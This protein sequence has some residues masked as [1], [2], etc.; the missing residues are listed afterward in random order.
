[1]NRQR[2]QFTSDFHPE[3]SGLDG[4]FSFQRSAA[5]QRGDKVRIG[6]QAVTATTSGA[7][8]TLFTVDTDSQ[9]RLGD[10]LVYNSTAGALTVYFMIDATVVMEEQ[11]PANFTEVYNF[12]D[13][14]L[15]AAEVLKVYAS[16]TGITVTGTAERQNP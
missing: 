3:G 5:P 10:M 7:A 8:H 15:Y 4:Q 11:I 1:M 9:L 12:A 13:L 14:P 16:A 6:P 2:R